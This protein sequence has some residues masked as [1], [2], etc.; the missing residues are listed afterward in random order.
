MSP[1]RFK[2]SSFNLYNLA[3]PEQK[4]YDRVYSRADYQQKIQWVA[5]QLGRMDS[6]IVGFQ[7]I[8]H[9]AALQEALDQ[10][11]KY[12]GASLLIANETGEK[13]VVGLAT[14]FPVL[15]HEVIGEFPLQAQ[16]EI[17]GMP[18]PIKNFSRPVL[19][20]KLQIRSTLELVVFVTH[21]KSKNPQIGEGMDRHNPMERA[22]GKA[23]SLMVRAAEATALRCLLLD[24]LKGNNNPIVIMGDV[25]DD[26]QA[27][28]SEIIAGSPPWRKLPWEKKLKIWDTLLY[29]VKD[30][31][32]RQSY[33]DIYYT[34][35]HNGYYESLDHIFVSQEFLRQNPNHLGYVEYVSLLNDHLIDETLSEEEIPLWHSDHGQVTVTV[36]LRDS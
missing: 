13:P 22:L 28:T 7:E 36:R 27:V 11:S 21:L 19:R 34:H 1:N 3:L 6:D 15:D 18:I 33:R 9:S 8:F 24:Y 4:Y 2:I 35:I 30:I 5:G 29:N 32:A 26:G 12:Q 31:Q 10:S 23:R 20:V 17:E 25:N 16:L 14:R